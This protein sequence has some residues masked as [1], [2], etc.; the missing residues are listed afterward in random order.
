[1]DSVNTAIKG[2]FYA[3]RTDIFFLFV[4]LKTAMK[5]FL[6]PSPHLSQDID[7]IKVHYP[8]MIEVMADLQ[9]RNC[10]LAR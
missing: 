7:E 9:G 5:Q 2:H 1:M 6:C 8:S 10:P 3:D 4:I